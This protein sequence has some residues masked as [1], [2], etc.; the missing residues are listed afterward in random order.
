MDWLKCDIK[1]KTKMENI[2]CITT[3]RIEQIMKLNAILRFIV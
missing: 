2:Y 3:D 1:T